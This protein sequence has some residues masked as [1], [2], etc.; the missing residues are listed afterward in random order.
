MLIGLP[1][2]YVCFH[3]TMAEW[4]SCPETGGP[5]KS[6]IFIIWPFEKKFADLWAEPTGSQKAGTFI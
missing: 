1:I 3:A 4:S 5:A 6:E 2:V